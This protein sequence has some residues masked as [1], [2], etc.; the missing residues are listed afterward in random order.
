MPDDLT[1]ELTN[2]PQIQRVL[3]RLGAEVADGTK[4]LQQLD[5][6]T[7]ADIQREMSKAKATGG[8]V[9]GRK[10]KGFADQYTR[11]TDGVTVP[12]W[13]GVKKLHSPGNVKG[14]KRPS[15]KR[16]K[17]TSILNQ[18]TG[19]FAAALLAS[20][21]QIVDKGRMLIIGGKNLLPSYAEHILKLRP[22]LYWIPKDKRNYRR[23]TIDHIR[24]AVK[25]A[26]RGAK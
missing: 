3:D 26:E 8:V 17:K 11:K 6:I 23:L 16:V 20:R 7:R 14:R 10:Q 2:G 5:R 19:A 24:A 15:G 25:R 4:V 9:R 18:D 12:A 22:L 13:G 21:A 1:I